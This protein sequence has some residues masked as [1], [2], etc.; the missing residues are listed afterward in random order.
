M[1]LMSDESYAVAPV[2][3]DPVSR[4]LVSHDP[5]SHDPVSRESGEEVVRYCPTCSA[6]YR[7]RTPFCS[8]DGTRLLSGPDP[9]IGQTLAGRYQIA[10]ALGWGAMGR[11]YRAE[12][13]HLGRTCAIKVLFGE[14]AADE[15]MRK[16][17]AREAKA[18]A[19]LSHP[20]LVSVSD[21]GQSEHGLSFLVMDYIG[22]RS[23]SALIGDEAPLEEERI[24]GLGISL[25]EGLAYLHDRGMVHRDLKPDNV[26]VTRRGELEVPCILDFGLAI[27]YENPEQ[28]RCTAE[29]IVCGTPS[30]MSPEHAL[31]APLDPRTDLYSLGVIL[32]E[33]IAGVTPFSGDNYAV[34][35]AAA[36][37]PPPPI[38]ERNPSACP[39]PA[40][41]ALVMSLLSKDVN[42]RPSSAEEVA[43]VLG[44]IVAAGETET[45]AVALEPSAAR[46]AAGAAREPI[47][48]PA[49]EDCGATA[50]SNRRSRLAGA[51]R[52][53]LLAAVFTL[54]SA[55]GGELWD[56]AT[57]SAWGR[58]SR[59]ELTLAPPAIG[60][61]GKST[62]RLR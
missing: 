26:I 6:V 30:Y 18:A 38:R 56:A 44:S 54:L 19:L 61:G 13:L 7:S 24:V 48:T 9:L 53:G 43:A 20:N 21:F 41:E 14:L 57:D 60:P 33:M 29:G 2:S 1:T 40:L 42:L 51:A 47:S 36:V 10:S 59:S 46:P 34:A 3:H 35:V 31:D 45:A 8:G 11:V 4:D 52:A 22:G 12:H 23:L 5:V 28:A 49:P 27:P 39:S 25:C 55:A 58:D 32:Y 15:E 37:S 62:A 16:R 17:F 50:A